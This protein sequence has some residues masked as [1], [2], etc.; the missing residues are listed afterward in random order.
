M[1]RP[2][3]YPWS[4]YHYNALGK[5]DELVTPHVL[6]H[7]LGP[8]EEDRCT[9]YRRFLADHISADDYEFIRKATAQGYDEEGHN[10]T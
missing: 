2:D 3:K 5:P 1:V 7:Q 8:G 9:A 4:S 10:L 6:Y